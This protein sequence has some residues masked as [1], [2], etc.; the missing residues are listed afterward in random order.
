MRRLIAVLGFLIACSGGDHDSSSGSSSGSGS[1]GNTCTPGD[2]P[3][4]KGP[5]FDQVWQ[6]ATHNSYWVN[7]GVSDPFASGVQERFADQMLVDHARSVEI[8]IH[9]DD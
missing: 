5:R 2:P 6:I 9:R 7:H 8:D 1:G 3:K 4:S